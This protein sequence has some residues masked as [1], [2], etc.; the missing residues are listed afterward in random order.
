[1]IMNPSLSL[2]TI[3]Q[4]RLKLLSRHK[5]VKDRGIDRQRDGQGAY[6]SVPDFQAGPYNKIFHL[7]PISYQ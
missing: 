3:D 1:M 6:Y 4:F 7:K 2:N 5:Y